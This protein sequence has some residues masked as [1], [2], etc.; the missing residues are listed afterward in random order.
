MLLLFLLPP[1]Q[2]TN[3]FWKSVS[4]NAFSAAGPVIGKMITALI[5]TC[6]HTSAKVSPIGGMSIPHNVPAAV[7][8]GFRTFLSKRINPISVIVIYDPYNGSHYTLR[9]VLILAV[10]LLGVPMSH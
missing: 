6:K 8:V 1:A 7:M 5:P 3:S 4:I 9:S 2:G 10:N